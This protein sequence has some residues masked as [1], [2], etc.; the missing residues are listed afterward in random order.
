MLTYADVQRIYRVEKNATALQK[1]PDNFYSEVKIL[2]SNISEE[3]RTYIM[4][5]LSEIQEKRRNKLLIQAMRETESPANLIPEEKELY[6]QIITVIN[7]YQNKISPLSL[8]A[9]KFP[10]KEAILDKPAP[11]EATEQEI[12]EERGDLEKIEDPPGKIKLKILKPLPEIIGPDYV[13]YG[14][15]FENQEVMLPEK[16]AKILREKEV[17]EKLN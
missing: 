9:S 17:A 5:L 12:K 15:F 8:E 7:D 13:K 10:E 11:E 2:L 14:P 6:N 4:K 3:Y 16:M 1:I